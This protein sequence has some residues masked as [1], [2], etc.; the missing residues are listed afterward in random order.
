MDIPPK[1]IINNENNDIKDGNSEM[2]INE[3]AKQSAL[4][5]VKQGVSIVNISELAENEARKAADANMAESYGSNKI[6]FFKKMWKHTFFDEYYRQKEVNKVK[7]EIDSTGNIYTGRLENK[8]KTAH[9]NTMKAISDR[10]TS[11]YEG[12]LA[13]GEAKKMLDDKDPETI[14]AKTELKSLI[15]DYAMSKIDEEAFK[16]GKNN[17]IKILKGEDLLKG[18]NHY[19]DNLFEIAQNAR[20]AIEHGAKIE[21]LDF[22]LE[23]VIGKA[24]SSLKTEAH[25]NMID[26]AVDW[27]NKT[28][29]GKFISPAVVSTAIG[30]TYSLSVGLSKKLMTSKA[31][32]LFSLGGSVALAALS[33]G[34][35]ASRKVVLDKKQRDIEAAEGSETEKG[36]KSR[37]QLD[38]FAYTME[39]SNVL[40]QNLRDLMFDIDKDGKDVPKD[41]KQEDI[42][43]IIASLG[44]IDARKGL[45]ARNKIDLISYSGIGNVEKESTDLTILTARAKVELRKRLEG[46]LKDGLKDGKTFEA[47]LAEQTQVIE[48]TLLGGEKGITAQDKA[49]RK[50]K[51]GRI[52][53]KMAQTAVVGLIIG[54]T[55]QEGLAFFKD[56]VQGFVEGLVKPEEGHAS[57]QTPFEH[58]RGWVSG[59]PSHM[60][61][62]NAITAVFNGHDINIPEGTSLVNNA[63]GTF[64]LLRGDH[65]VTSHFQPTFDVN[66]GLDAASI[67]RLGQDG[68][69]ATAT[70]SVIDST[71]E[72][73]GSAQD[74]LANHPGETINVNHDLW[75]GNDTG[76]NV[77][78]ETGKLLGA[79]L[80]ELGTHWGGINGTGV[81]ENGD[82]VL[83]I[84]HMT[85]GGSFQDGLSVNAQEAM[86]KGNLMAM[87]FLD[88]S[89]QGQG[90]PVPIDASGNII[91]DHNNPLM[92]QIFSPGP[93]GHMVSHAKFIEIVQKMGID[94]NGVEHIRTL[95]TVV[96]EGLDKIKDIVPSHVDVTIDN[97]SPTMGTEMPLFVPLVAHRPLGKVNQAKEIKP[98]QIS[99]EDI[100]KIDVTTVTKEDIDKIDVAPVVADDIDKIEKKDVVNKIS[101]EE[102]DGMYDDLKMINKK[103]QSSEGVLT[104]TE[105]DFKSAYGKKRYNELNHIE[106]GKNITWNKEEVMKIGDELDGLLSISK[107][108]ETSNE[109]YKAGDVVEFTDAGIKRLDKSEAEDGR[110]INKGESEVNP[111]IVKTTEVE[112]KTVTTEEKK[113]PEEVLGKTPTNISTAEKVFTAKDLSKIGTEF[114]SE[115]GSFKVTKVIS[116]G[117]F[118]GFFGKTKIEAIY[119][120]SKG[121][122]TLVSYDKNEL[123][124]ELKNGNIKITKAEQEKTK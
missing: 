123:E 80:N 88:G 83:N 22:D 120:D 66:G 62:G 51:A 45:N 14:K 84:S 98:E 81:A 55:I 74:W 11:D 77:D 106:E 85:P 61:M 67:Q 90:I 58:I 35:G 63:D 26:K 65:V 7:E 50:Y 96:G 56:D 122:E 109:T 29:V 119:T 70:H 73:T 75:Y 72:I 12:T 25:F 44:E 121:V 30:L 28:P 18:A 102:Y 23:I 40:A 39:S 59:N 68:I 19:A 9:E 104:L 94:K 64:D 33:A 95:S 8:D 38:R 13:E 31:A 47:L 53:K 15:N 87:I 49:F 91:F 115:S 60:G 57:I 46:D 5:K 82:Y 100:N 112:Q 27:T 1:K 86:G 114:K 116:S 103:E 17:S 20:L 107:K 124:G 21:E 3:S 54:G 36:D 92:Q 113:K 93:D 6:G 97:L 108:V 89:H 78:P 37:E 41:I 43:K 2:Q 4:E 32:A 71:K 76:M 16:T 42:D 101:K 111:E 99:E 117:G 52:A 69:L 79:D 110:G 10:F 118:F 34:V 105:K 24:K 48:D